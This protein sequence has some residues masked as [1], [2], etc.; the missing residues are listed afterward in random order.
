[1]AILGR[2]TSRALFD[3]AA[4]PLT[5]PIFCGHAGTAPEQIAEVRPGAFAA[6]MPRRLACR[7]PGCRG[8]ERHESRE[9]AGGRGR[10]SSRPT[11]ATHGL[12]LIV[13]GSIVILLAVLGHRLICWIVNSG[14]RRP[15]TGSSISGL[16][17]NATVGRAAS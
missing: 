15:C 13:L 5:C 4:S 10:C 7:G 3:C 17:T 6:E 12:A 8:G 11:S 2:G 1:M 14:D 9:P 16:E